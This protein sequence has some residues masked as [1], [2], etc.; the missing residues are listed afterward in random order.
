MCSSGICQSCV[1]F[2]LKFYLN[3][4][5]SFN[6]YTDIGIA[7]KKPIMFYFIK[8]Y[9]CVSDITTHCIVRCLPNLKLHCPGP[10]LQ[11]TSHP[12]VVFLRTTENE[13]LQTGL[14]TCGVKWAGKQSSE[15]FLEL[16]D[17]PDVRFPEVDTGTASRWTS[18]GKLLGGH[19]CSLP[20][21][22]FVIIN[23]QLMIRNYYY[24][25]KFSETSIYGHGNDLGWYL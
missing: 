19:A 15:R 16:K 18:E 17:L 11:N 14:T 8:K 2:W 7:H 12:F 4:S 9:V 23:W 6:V 20:S 21:P 22:P 10:C 3:N 24:F 5:L 1:I 25:L 13:T